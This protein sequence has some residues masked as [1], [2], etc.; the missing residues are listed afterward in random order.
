MCLRR[1][2]SRDTVVSGSETTTLRHKSKSKSHNKH[3][4]EPSCLRRQVSDLS[5]QDTEEAL[6]LM[7]ATLR[8]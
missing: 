4:S 5:V 1:K 8:R 2:G 3:R 7:D 6:E